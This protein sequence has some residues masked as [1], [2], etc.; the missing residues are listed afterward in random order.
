MPIAFSC[1]DAALTALP[2]VGVLQGAEDRQTVLESIKLAGETLGSGMKEF[3][4][5]QQKMA[6][7]A[8]TVTAVALGIYS[9]KVQ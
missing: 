4:S 5:D 8:T 1:I 7:A 3:L 6:A 2:S 9:A